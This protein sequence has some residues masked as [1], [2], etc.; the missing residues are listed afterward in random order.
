MA[1]KSV[2]IFPG[3]DEAE[4]SEV[5]GKGLSLMIG[6]KS[7]LP[8]PPGFILSVAFFAPW[9]TKL[10]RTPAW[11]AFANANDKLLEKSC[12]H[13]KKS[14]LPFARHLRRKILKV[15]H[16]PADMKRSSE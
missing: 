1:S 11:K 7:A 9:F 10:R 15:R 4:L 13:L 16:L 2:Y 3:S 14:A 5:G 8:V 6:S 12:E